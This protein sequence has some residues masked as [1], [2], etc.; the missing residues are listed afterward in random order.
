MKIGF[1]TYQ[2]GGPG[3][4]ETIALSLACAIKEHGNTVHIVCSKPVSLPPEIGVTQ[5]ASIARPGSLR[6]LSFRFTSSRA[7]RSLGC[8]ILHSFGM[9]KHFNVFSAQSCHKAGLKILEQYTSRLIENPFGKGVANTLA[10]WQ[11]RRNFSVAPDKKIIACSQRTKKE[12]LEEYKIEENNVTVIPNGIDLQRFY[13]TTEKE[14]QGRAILRKA[15]V[16]DSVPVILFVGNEFA[17]K[18]LAALIQSLPLL[19]G[20]APHIVVAGNGHTRPYR[21]LAAR[22]GIESS[23]HFLGSVGEID[24]LYAAAHLLVL[25]ALHEAFGLVIIEAMA[26]GVPVIASARAGAVEDLATNEKHCLTLRT[27]EQP[28]E[29]AAAIQRVFD[30]ST[31]QDRM[32]Q[33]GMALARRIPWIDVALQYIEV[34]QQIV[35]NKTQ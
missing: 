31:L 17:R 23:V 5:V 3:G 20:Q 7:A 14:A 13:R 19:K 34:Y 16:P 26:M 27:P 28:E 25:P 29:I 9:T 1:I 33:A 24:R 11:E 6:H 8:D 35:T 21:Q 4:I 15:G 32:I 10:L 12:I 2:C 18:G 30:D 22:L